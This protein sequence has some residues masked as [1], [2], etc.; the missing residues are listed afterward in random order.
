MR[1][2][3]DCALWGF[4]VIC[5]SVL[6]VECAERMPGTMDP[7]NVMAYFEMFLDD[8]AYTAEAAAKTLGEVEYFYGAGAQLTPKIPDVVSAA[9]ELLPEDPRRRPQSLQEFLCGVALDFQRD[10]ALRVSFDELTRKF[11]EPHELPLPPPRLL[12]GQP[13]RPDYSYGFDAK[14]KAFRGMLILTVD[15]KRTGDV[16]RVIRV[17]YRRYSGR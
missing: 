11:G 14:G 4:V 10:K 2:A 12:P 15:G 16:N 6:G 5:S 7:K 17:S 9:L 3:C 1:L 8:P 13:Y